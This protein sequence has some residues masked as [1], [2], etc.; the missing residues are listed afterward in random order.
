MNITKEDH[1]LFHTVC[2]MSYKLYHTLNRKMKA[3]WNWHILM[4]EKALL[5]QHDMQNRYYEWYD[6]LT[7]ELQTKTDIVRSNVIDVRNNKLSNLT[8]QTLPKEYTTHKEWLQI[9]HNIQIELQREL[10]NTLK[11]HYVM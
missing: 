1:E 2:D 8:W 7:P 4:P 11:K 5:V 9:E 10:L 6:M 3:A